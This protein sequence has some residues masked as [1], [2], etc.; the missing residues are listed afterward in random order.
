[1]AK[2]RSNPPKRKSKSASTPKSI[3]HSASST[4]S[5]NPHGPPPPPP[6][7]PPSTSTLLA[8]AATALHTEGSPS[9]A[10]R[11]TTL[12]LQ[13]D[14]TSLAALELAGEAH[15]ELGDEDTA[16]THFEK[17]AALD[18]DGALSGPEKFLWLAQ[19]GVGGKAMMGWYERGT[20]VLR[21][22]MQEGR[23]GEGGDRGL[24]GKLC[25]ALCAMAEIYMSDL[26]DEPDAESR[27][28]AYVTEALLVSPHSAEALQTL[29]SIR[30]S[31][32]RPADA[33]TALQRSLAL[34]RELPADAAGV[35]SY[36]A[37]INLAKLLIETRQYDA[38]LEV[39]ERL[40]LEDDQLPDLWYLGG[41]CLFLYG[42]QEEAGSEE[43]R[44][45][46]GSAREWL[47]NCGLVYEALGWEDVGIWEHAEELRGRIGEEVGESEGE[48]EE[49][50]GGEEG[51]EEWESEEEE[52]VEMK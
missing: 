17:A 42:E 21:A 6:P 12:A 32:Q 29:A 33:V 18:P 5:T 50:E 10:L 14:P 22:W 26:C 1:M 23:G 38:A 3:L 19:L 24:Q 48:G 11:L 41:W 31:Q 7:P 4:F 15:L 27:C 28:E 43:R 46:W 49:G 51:E 34:W 20:A 9:D 52:D 2:T 30:I 25:S 39:L 36:A 8:S 45:L 13:S 44:E 47:G 40:Q 37:R 16:R 35:P